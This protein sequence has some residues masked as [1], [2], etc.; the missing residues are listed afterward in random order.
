MESKWKAKMVKLLLADA[1]I[2]AAVGW[3]VYPARL[4]T[5][6]E[7]KFPCINFADEGGAFPYRTARFATSSLRFWFYSEKSIDAATQLYELTD[8]ILRNHALMGSKLSMVLDPSSTLAEIHET[9][10]F[11]VTMNYFTR[12]I[13]H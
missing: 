11:G 4:A 5:V 7:P 10:L 3:R 6:I 8:A 13:H 9:G 12:S 1:T 2:S